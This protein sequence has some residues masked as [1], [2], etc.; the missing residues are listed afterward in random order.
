MIVPGGD[1]RYKEGER[2]EDGGFIGE[3]K[4]RCKGSE[5][6]LARPYISHEPWGLITGT[7][8]GRRGHHRRQSEA[9][10]RR[11][12]HVGDSPVF[13]KALARWTAASEPKGPKCR[14]AK[15]LV[16]AFIKVVARPAELVGSNLSF[17]RR[18]SVSFVLR[19]PSS[20]KRAERRQQQTAESE[21]AV[22]SDR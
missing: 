2:T 21:F 1:H 8:S 16:K 13:R 11:R 22:G 9:R 12:H 3:R 18:S 6:S 17:S 10:W 20:S 5:C 15:G 7:R 4:W 19:M 14:A